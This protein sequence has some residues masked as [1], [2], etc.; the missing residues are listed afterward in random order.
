MQDKK[1]FSIDELQEM[2]Q[3]HFRKLG[4]KVLYATSDGQF[5]VLEN[6]AMLHA[7]AG[8]VVRT[9]LDE[10]AA[11][12]RAEALTLDEIREAAALLDKTESL[13][14]MM[15]EEVAGAN[16]PEAFSI[17]E[18]RMVELLSAPATRGEVPAEP[19]ATVAATTVAPG[20][21]VRDTP[22]AQPA[23]V[24]PTEAEKER[25]AVEAAPVT[26]PATETVD[27]ADTKEPEEKPAKAKE[28]E[29]KPATKEKKTTGK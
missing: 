14:E 6:R 5:F 2:A 24:A 17:I 11:E 13:R 18:A 21:P 19:K 16:R 25:A 7:G 12:V 20:D 1:F 26:A 9:I 4:V 8:G 28:Q 10:G 29:K 27:P 23:G 3:E 22:D 15:L